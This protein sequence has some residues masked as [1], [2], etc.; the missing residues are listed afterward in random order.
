[1]MNP[2]PSKAANADSRKH[3]SF[4]AYFWRFLVVGIL[5]FTAACSDDYSDESN[6]ADDDQAPPAAEVLPEDDAEA[7]STSGGAAQSG[8]LPAWTVILYEDADDETLEED[9]YYDLNEAELVGSTDDVQIVS[10]FDRYDGGFDGDGDWTSTKRF[11]VTQDDDLYSLNSEELDDLGELNMSDGQTLADFVTWAVEN[12]PAQ[13]Y[14]LI[15]SDHGMGWPGGWTDPDPDEEDQLYLDEIVGA[16]DAVKQSTGLEKFELI[17]FD[18]CLMS[19]LEVYTA[20]EP[21]ANYAVASQETEPA[22]G[23]AYQAFLSAMTDDPQISGADLSARIVSSYIDEDQRIVDDEARSELIGKEV[24]AKKAA[25]EYNGD[26]TLTAVDL[27]KLPDVLNALNGFTDS[28]TLIDQTDVAESRAYAQSF[29]SVFGDEEPPSYIDLGNF[30]T[31]VSEMAGVD[32]ITAAAEQLNT[33]ISSAVI[34]EKH[35]DDRPGATGIAIYFPVSDLYISDDYS[36]IQSYT[37]A[38]TAFAEQTAWDDFLAYHY[39]LQEYEPQ[40]GVVAA[41]TN[42]EDAAAPGAEELSIDN[43]AVSAEELSADEPITVSATVSGSNI[44][45]VYSFVGYYDEDSNSVWIADMDYIFADDTRQMGGVYYPDWGDSDSVEVSYDWDG[46]IFLISNGDESAY[47]LIQPQDYGAPDENPTYAVQGE[48]TFKK[49]GKTVSAV[50][51]FKDGEMLSVYGY[52]G[53]NGTGGMT[54]IVPKS[55]DSF[56]ITDDWI[57]FGADDSQE[58]VSLAGDTLTFGDEPFTWV[59]DWG[60]TGTYY[61]GFVAEDFDGNQYYSYM[62]VTVPEE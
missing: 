35:G 43:L 53:A 44:A 18:A 62:P 15:L 34:A 52:T 33:A 42:V 36:G 46:T 32:E 4:F 23:W 9:M 20:L 27:A 21:Y 7:N 51:Y 31:L 2:A 40:V 30:A 12:Y 37:S 48:Y 49:S 5:L 29:E 25:A 38:V 3:G 56:T 50:A 16:L 60:W 14:A 57:Q 41:P 10:Q 24:S 54:E 39:G 19:Q 58:F 22:M 45:F 17:G 11:Y 6:P 55:G 61:V 59:N 13:R 28:M 8:D 26:I 47:A 1:M